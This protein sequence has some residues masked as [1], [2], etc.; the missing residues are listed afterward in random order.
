M[1]IFWRNPDI[2]IDELAK[3]FKG[4]DEGDT[5][6]IIQYLP[7]RKQQMFTCLQIRFL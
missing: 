7:K 4:M 1:N 3:A 2:D 5:D 6:P